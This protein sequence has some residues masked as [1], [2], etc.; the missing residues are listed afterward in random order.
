MLRALVFLPLSGFA[1]YPSDYAV[2]PSLYSKLPYDPRRA[3]FDKWAQVV[4]TANI[5][6]D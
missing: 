5:K 2:N 4:R 6:L 1:Q 3:E